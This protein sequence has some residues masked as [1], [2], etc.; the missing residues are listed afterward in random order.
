MK[1]VDGHAVHKYCRRIFLES[2][3]GNYRAF[4]ICPSGGEKSVGI[5]LFS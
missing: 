2:Q 1:S 5:L 3:N 4:V